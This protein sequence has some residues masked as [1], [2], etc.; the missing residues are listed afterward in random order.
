MEMR[1]SKTQM[2][3]PMAAKVVAEEE[4]SGPEVM[5]VKPQLKEASKEVE[6]PQPE[7]MAEMDDK[8]HFPRG[9][10]GGSITI[11]GPTGTAIGGYGGRGGASGYGR[12]GDGG[13]GKHSSPGTAIGGNGGDAGRPHRPALGGASGLERSP[14]IIS[15]WGAALPTDIYGIFQ[16]GSGGDSYESTIEVRGRAY[17]FNILLRLLQIWE[18]SILDTI[19]DLEHT[20]EQDW[21][22][23]ACFHFPEKTKKAID[24]M[25][26][27]E[28]V[29]APQG[30]PPETP[31]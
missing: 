29:T 6:V 15:T 24:H 10:N 27:C 20:N 9:G 28:D 23:K 19:D 7:E 13:G 18:H 16:H 17:S 21:W 2:A 8:K 26:Y 1:Q 31:Y 14:D 11:T 30:L 25:T 3:A 4:N 12:G 22:D 5:A